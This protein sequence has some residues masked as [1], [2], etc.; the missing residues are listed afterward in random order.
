MQNGEIGPISSI[1]RSLHLLTTKRRNGRFCMSENGFTLLEMMIALGLAALALI[2]LTGYTSFQTSRLDDRLT[3]EIVAQ[4]LA[5]ELITDPRPPAL[6]SV[7]GERQNLGRSFEWTRETSA[8]NDSGIL[9]ITL[10]VTRS[11]IERV[12]QRPPYRLQIIRRLER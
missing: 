5:A 6:G 9:R 7:R 11:D 10:S 1:M 2:R 4:N 8:E 3:E 12:E